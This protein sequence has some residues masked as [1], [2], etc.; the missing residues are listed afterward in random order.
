MPPM[1]SPISTSGL[2]RWKRLLRS[3]ARW[4]FVRQFGPERREQDQR[5]QGGGANRVTLGDRLGRV[6]DRVERVGDVADVLGQVR[7]LGD[8]TGVVGDRPEGVEGDDQA[9]ERELGDDGDAD[10]VDARQLV[11]A[12][13]RE[14]DDERRSGGRLVALGEAGDD[15]RRVAG[16]RRRGDRLHRPEPGRRIKFGDSEQ[17]RGDGDADHGAEPEVAN[18]DGL[19]GG[20]GEAEPQRFAHQPVGDRVESRDRERSGDQQAPVQRTLDLVGLGPHAEGAD[21]RGDDRDAAENQRVDR[22]LAGVVGGEGED[23]E[24]HHGD[25]GDRVGLEQIGGHAGAVADVVADVVGDHGRVARIVLGDPGLDLADQVGADVSRLGEDAA[26]ETGEDGDQRA[27]EA[28]A[29]QRVD[30][31]LVGAAGDD[32]HAVVAGDAEQRQADDE[33]AGDRA[34][35]EGDVERRRHAAAGRLG[36]AAVGPHR[37]VHADEAGRPREGGADD[38]AD[39]G[40]V[41]LQDEQHHGDRHRDSGDDRVLTV[42]I[43][44]CAFLHGA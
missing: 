26:A 14:G 17:Q 44:L 20:V 13:D 15:V 21:D 36:D 35:F 31:L 38:E 33:K 2:V 8:T 18:A 19:G 41:V 29:D 43:G 7:H 25:R 5:R 4:G 32:Q 30:G 23:A 1:I 6:T 28:E 37:D 10:A 24:Q 27:T 42:Q 39:R 22:Y 9:A 11:G 12:E 40:L 34:A 3:K 16:L